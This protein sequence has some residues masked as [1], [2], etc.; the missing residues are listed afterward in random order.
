MEDDFMTQLVN[1]LK[2]KTQFFLEFSQEFTAWHTDA[3]EKILSA[4]TEEESYE[5]FVRTYPERQAKEVKYIL[6]NQE[7]RL[8]LAELASFYAVLDD[9][10][11]LEYQ[12]K[13]LLT[14]E[15]ITLLEGERAKSAVAFVEATMAL[16]KADRN[17]N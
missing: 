15:N 12:R 8:L 7:I 4:K 9:E 14:F 13:L 2:E 5:E 16:T 17:L 10:K 1:Q 6:L 3:T 11:S